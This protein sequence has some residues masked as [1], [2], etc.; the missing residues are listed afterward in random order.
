[1]W[2]LQA[3]AWFGSSLLALILLMFTQPRGQRAEWLVWGVAMWIAMAF[4]LA[5]TS[6]Q[7]GWPW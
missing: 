4:I 6:I 7:W 5:A 3:A 1:M 2:E